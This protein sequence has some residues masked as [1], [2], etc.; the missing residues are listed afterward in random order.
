MAVGCGLPTTAPRRKLLFHSTHGGREQQMTPPPDC[1]RRCHGRG[2]GRMRL[3][4][5]DYT[6]SVISR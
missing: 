3:V 4:L 6:K 2:E 1:T 5:A